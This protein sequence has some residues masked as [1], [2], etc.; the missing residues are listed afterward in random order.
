MT[1]YLT[2]VR[3]TLNTASLKE[4]FVFTIPGVATGDSLTVATGV[5]SAFATA[6]AGTPS[7]STLVDSRTVFTEVTAAEILNM[8]T[9]TLKAASHVP[10]TPT[11]Q[12]SSP[13]ALP[14]QL[15]VCISTAGGSKPNGTPYRGRFYLPGPQA[16]AISST[17]GLL[18]V[19]ASWLS[20][21]KAFFLA[22]IANSFVPAVWSRKDGNMNI[23]TQLRVGDRVDTIRTRRNELAETYTT[24]TIP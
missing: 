3:G 5:K 2:T 14:S 22:M 15:A 23:I 19:P 6:W 9:G 12:G 24:T 7:L 16:A 8:N 20:F 10:F 18:A 21:S 1:N 4:I 11:L 17:N 13:A